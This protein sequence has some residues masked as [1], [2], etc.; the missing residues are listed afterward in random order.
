MRKV[1]L[2]F[3]LLGPCIGLIAQQPLNNTDIIKLVK[4]GLSDDFIVSTI[5]SQPGNYDASPEAIIALKNAGASDR[6]MSAVVQ[7][8]AGT[9]AAAPPQATPLPTPVGAPV[10]APADVPA[11]A[12]PAGAKLVL[13]EG[14]DVPLVFDQDLS[15]KTAA[16]GDSVA[17]VLSEDIK[18]GS[19]VVAKAGSKA[20]GEVTNAKKSGMMGKAGELN[21]RLDYLKVGSFKVHLRGARGKE[22]ESGTTGVVV[23]TVLFGPIGLIKHGQNIDI[24]KGTAMK[25]YVADDISLPP[26]I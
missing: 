26:A 25:V 20:F 11:P 6:V 18:V 15:S 8:V 21:V 17:F 13:A 1:L 3:A 9:A 19:V 4:A 7:K 24:K 2:A 23:L 16:E 10:A 5:T 22:G 12:V 14:T